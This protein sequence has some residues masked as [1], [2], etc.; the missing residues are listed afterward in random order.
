[1]RI[2]RLA[3]TMAAVGLLLILAVTWAVALEPPLRP[4]RS[5]EERVLTESVWVHKP[6][7]GTR[8]SPATRLLLKQQVPWLSDNMKSLIR[9]IGLGPRSAEAEPLS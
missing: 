1:M 8:Q 9:D 7:K 4:H 2:M 3:L 5:S 6:I